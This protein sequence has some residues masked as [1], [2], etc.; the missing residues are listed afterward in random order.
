M[1]RLEKEGQKWGTSH[2]HITSRLPSWDK[3]KK[4]V[5]DFYFLR[6]R[7]NNRNF[8]EGVFFRDSSIKHNFFFK[9]ST[10]NFGKK[11]GTSDRDRVA[12]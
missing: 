5:R 7:E 12:I 2:T 4:G 8:L 9:E 10:W 11:Q 3:K 1:R 6:D